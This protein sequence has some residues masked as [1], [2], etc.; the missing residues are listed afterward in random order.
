MQFNQL[1][2]LGTITKIDIILVKNYKALPLFFDVIMK[3]YLRDTKI[4]HKN[5]Q[6]FSNWK[7]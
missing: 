2:L 5:F 3:V 1:L 4:A 6:L 7:S